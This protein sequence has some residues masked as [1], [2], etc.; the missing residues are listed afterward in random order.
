MTA[1]N[2]VRPHAVF[3]GQDLTANLA[4]RGKPHEQHLCPQ[5]PWNEQLDV[6]RW[7]VGFS[8]GPL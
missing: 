3:E 6:H 7:N 1:F 4:G 2:F 8:E 5:R